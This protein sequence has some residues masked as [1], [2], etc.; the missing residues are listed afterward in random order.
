MTLT[1]Y[2]TTMTGDD[3]APP[4]RRRRGYLWEVS[5]LPGGA[6]DGN[7]AITAMTLADF[8]AEGDL[9]EQHQLWP[10]IA[11]WCRTRPHRT[12][13]DQPG[14]PARQPSA[15][16]RREKRAA[17]PRGGTMTARGS[18]DHDREPGGRRRPGASQ[19][20]C[21]LAAA[22]PRPPVG[23]TGTCRAGAWTSVD[24]AARLACP[25][26]CSTT[27]CAAATWPTRLAWRW[28]ITLTLAAV[29]SASPPRPLT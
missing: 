12:R 27:R 3:K 6:L 20:R 8:S 13:R 9:N 7:S 17:R 22:P 16:S 19:V 25:A 11:T 15:A 14:L 1:I 10:F 23:P 26:T 21:R 29:P 28:L 4:R 2:D 24:E 5:W 18:P